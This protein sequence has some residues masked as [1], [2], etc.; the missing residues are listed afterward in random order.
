MQVTLE[1]LEELIDDLRLSQSLSEEGDRGC[2]T[3]CFYYSKSDRLLEGAPVVHLIFHPFI[4]ET[5]QLL[6]DPHL[7]ENRRI[8][9]LSLLVALLVLRVTFLR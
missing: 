7:E 8:N 1:H 2:I 9:P 3:N 4:A 6:K 5:E